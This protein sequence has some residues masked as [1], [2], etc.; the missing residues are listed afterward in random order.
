M[1]SNPI[2]A[3]EVLT[4]ERWSR[5]E[6]RPT[7]RSPSSE[8]TPQERLV[9]LAEDTLD[10]RPFRRVGHDDEAARPPLPCAFEGRPEL[11]VQIAVLRQVAGLQ[12][13]LDQTAQQR[14]FCR[15][16]TTCVVMQVEG[17]AIQ[18][19]LQERTDLL[20]DPLD[21]SE[22]RKLDQARP[23]CAELD[24]AWDANLHELCGHERR[25][26][27]AQLE[28]DIHVAESGEGAHLH[29]G[30]L[31]ALS[32]WVHDPDVGD[33]P[34]TVELCAERRAYVTV[35]DSAPRSPPRRR[36]RRTVGDSRRSGS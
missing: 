14:P 5:E 33:D 6:A 22:D 13:A 15:G 26:A 21:P 1:G 19:A 27:P 7:S 16:E 25:F 23:A 10:R 29:E 36:G 32:P 28:A 30:V 12:L 3:T 2:R 31:Q 35:P 9:R 18:S 17:I 24:V 34:P 20:G 4:Q 8:R 11:Q